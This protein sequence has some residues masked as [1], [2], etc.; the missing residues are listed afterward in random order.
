MGS[1][2]TPGQDF[3]RQYWWQVWDVAMTSRPLSVINVQAR[4]HPLIRAALAFASPPRNV[5]RRAVQISCAKGRRGPGI[6]VLPAPPHFD[7]G[8]R[9]QES[10]R[11]RLQELYESD[12]IFDKFQCASNPDGTEVATGSYGNVCSVYNAGG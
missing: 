12:M 9:A 2:V 3:T 10:M 11:G 1:Y 4:R 6:H 8:D 7:F 5:I